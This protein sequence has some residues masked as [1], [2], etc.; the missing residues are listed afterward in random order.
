[1]TST[2]KSTIKTKVEISRY[3]TN[4]SIRKRVDKLLEANA[5]LEATLGLDSSISEYKDVKRQQ[6]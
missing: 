6:R 3:Y 1:M 4:K 5:I 2:K